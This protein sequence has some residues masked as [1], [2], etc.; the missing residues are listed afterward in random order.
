MGKIEAK[1][2]WLIKE[3]INNSN[4]IIKEDGTVY[5]KKNKKLGYTFKS[6]SKLRNKS[7]VYIKYKGKKLKLHRIIFAKFKG[8]L[9][10]SYVIHHKDG[11]SLNNAVDNLEQVC[12]KTNVYHRFH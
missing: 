7:Y 3:F 4:Y 1:Y 6:E 9:R 10:Q 12:Q 11:N 5:N 8:T 2:N